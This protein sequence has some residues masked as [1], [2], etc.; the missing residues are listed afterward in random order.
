MK[1]VVHCIDVL[2]KDCDGDTPLHV[3]MYCIMVIIRLAR[4]VHVLN[5]CWLMVLNMI[6]LTM[7]E[8]QYHSLFHY[9]CVA[10]LVCC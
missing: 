10:Y 1:R 8:K 6:F 9:S 4:T 3:I 7:K 5:V 2:L